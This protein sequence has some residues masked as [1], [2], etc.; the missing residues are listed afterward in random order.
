MAATVRRAAAAET[1]LI[2][3]RWTEATLR[4]AQ[5]ALDAGFKPLSDL[6]ASAAYR[7]RVSRALLERLWLEMRPQAPLDASALRVWEGCA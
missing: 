5:A 1:A 3:Q 4:H 7:Q 6:R 2:G